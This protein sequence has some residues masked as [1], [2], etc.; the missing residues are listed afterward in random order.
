VRRI[1]PLLT[2]L[3]LGFAPAPFPKPEPRRPSDLA[4]LQ[5]EWEVVEVAD[6]KGRTKPSEAGVSVRFVIASNRVIIR[7]AGKDLRC[8]DCTADLALDP[9]ATP[10]QVTWKP[11]SVRSGDKTERAEDDLKL[12]GIYRLV[13][14]DLV[15]CAENDKEQKFPAS[16]DVSGSSRSVLVV[17]RRKRI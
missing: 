17:C 10:K 5:G 15:I 16:F 7:L 1:V 11:I 8:D 9:A 13:G 2:V 4:R 6:K 14:D 3:L 12:V